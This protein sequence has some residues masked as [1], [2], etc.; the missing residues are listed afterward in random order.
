MKKF[1]VYVIMVLCYFASNLVCS[2]SNTLSS[3]EEGMQILALVITLISSIAFAF[4]SFYGPQK[5]FSSERGLR[6]KVLSIFSIVIG[7]IKGISAVTAV[8]EN[9]ELF[10]I[11]VQPDMLFLLIV[12]LLNPAFIFGIT[13]F[14]LYKKNYKGSDVNRI[15]KHPHSDQ[16]EIQKERCLKMEKYSR[17]FQ[18]EALK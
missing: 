17:E 8:D 4:L 6:Y 3:N 12:S 16:I 10:N 13:L 1:L 9:A 15:V 14:V 18:E 5:I 11:I 2:I 7:M